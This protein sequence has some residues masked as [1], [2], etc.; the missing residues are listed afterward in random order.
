M[1]RSVHEKHGIKL[2]TRW[3]KQVYV[4]SVV[5][6]PTL[7]LANGEISYNASQANTGYPVDTHASFM[8]NLGYTLS[9]SSS[10]SCQT[11]G[12]WNQASPICGES[13]KITHFYNFFK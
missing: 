12:Y 7:S 9:G 5:T 3:F 2:I 4:F 6:C 8:C 13:N 10:S 11:S 1:M